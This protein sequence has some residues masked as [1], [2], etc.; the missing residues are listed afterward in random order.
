[1]AAILSRGRWLNIEESGAVFAGNLA[2]ADVR[3]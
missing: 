1:M 2:P 3:A